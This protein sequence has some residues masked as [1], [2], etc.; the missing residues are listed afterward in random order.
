MLHAAFLDVHHYVVHF[1]Y[2]LLMEGAGAINLE[3]TTQDQF[4]GTS[5]MKDCFCHII[6]EGVP[7][8]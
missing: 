3:V 2:S 6:A 5:R 4:K 1:P 8:S 7:S